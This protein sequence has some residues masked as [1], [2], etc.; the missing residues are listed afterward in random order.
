[1]TCVAFADPFVG[2]GGGSAAMIPGKHAFDAKHM[3]EYGLDPPEAA[4]S[5]DCSLKSRRFF[6]LMGGGWG[7]DVD[8]ACKGRDLQ[9]C[10]GQQQDR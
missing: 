7:E 1:M 5:K 3:A 10:H 8:L 2:C 9:T 6:C 4:T